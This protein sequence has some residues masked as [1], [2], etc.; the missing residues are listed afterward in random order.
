M[1]AKLDKALVSGAVRIKI[2]PQGAVAF[3]G[4]TEQERDGVTDNCAYRRIM[5]TGSPLA[6]AKIA[7]AE[8]LS[9]RTVDRKVIGQG[10]HY[11]GDTYHA[12]KG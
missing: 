5:A 6:R 10:G 7:A 1:A 4:L 3:V 2:G 9:G 11:H 8:A 12:H